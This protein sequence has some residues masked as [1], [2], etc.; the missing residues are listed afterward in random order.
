MQIVISPERAIAD[1]I[2]PN[3]LIAV[4]EWHEDRATTIERALGGKK[5][6]AFGGPVTFLDHR[7][8]EQ[9]A[10]EIRQVAAAVT[11]LTKLPAAA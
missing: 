9:M 7:R 8:H 6:R 5:K 3:S 4:A 10:S 1:G 2:S 11:R